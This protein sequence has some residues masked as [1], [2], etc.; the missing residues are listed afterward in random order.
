MPVTISNLARSIDLIARRCPLMGKIWIKI[1]YPD[2]EPNNDPNRE[3]DGIAASMTPQIARG[4]IDELAR[5]IKEAQ[6]K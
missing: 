3:Y 5:A 6:G 4:L 1:D 2:D